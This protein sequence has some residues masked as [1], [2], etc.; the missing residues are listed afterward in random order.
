MTLWKSPVDNSESERAYAMSF[1]KDKSLTARD[2]TVDALIHANDI[3]AARLDAVE[4]LVTELL[5]LIETPLTPAERIERIREIR[6][7][8]PDAPA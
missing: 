8:L 3:L 1:V 2:E 7:G 6:E 4:A 5:G